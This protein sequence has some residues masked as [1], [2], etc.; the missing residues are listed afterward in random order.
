VGLFPV[1]RRLP[2]LLLCL[3]LKKVTLGAMLV[4]SFSVGLALTLVASGVIAALSVRYASKRMGSK[5]AKF[6]R[7]APYFSVALIMVIGLY[8]GWHGWQ[9]I[10]SGHSH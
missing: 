4:L 8:V 6:A 5:F 1:R 9:G 2:F 10:M 7:R 3:Q